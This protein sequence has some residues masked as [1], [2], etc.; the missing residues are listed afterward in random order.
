MISLVIPCIDNHDF[1]KRALEYAINNSTTDDLQIIIVDN[2]SEVAYT[3]EDYPSVKTI[4]TPE[5]NLGVPLSFKMAAMAAE[6][7]II[8]YIHNDV[9]IHEQGWDARIQHEFDSKPNLG[10]AGFF[11]APWVAPTGGRGNSMS[12]MLGLI[13][14]S[15]ASD[16]GLPFEGEYPAV[17]LDGCAMIFRASMMGVIGFD[18]LPPH[19]WYDRIWPLVMIY[20]GYDVETIGIAFDHD[21]GQT[22]GKKQYHESGREWLEDYGYEVRDDIGIDQQIYDAGLEI[23]NQDWAWRLPLEV[24]DSFNYRWWGNA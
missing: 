18:N 19:H 13:G 22:A 12:N 3:F 21:T 10:M 11:G 5:S 17:V 4:L 1:T 14:G 15:K 8:V 9:Y 16:H 7:D 2:G 23:F 6:G 24:D 20:R